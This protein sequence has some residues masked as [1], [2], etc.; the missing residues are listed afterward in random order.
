MELIVHDVVY[1]IWKKNVC[2]RLKLFL[3]LLKELFGI[4]TVLNHVLVLE[5]ALEPLFWCRLLADK[6]GVQGLSCSSISL[7]DWR[8]VSSL[9]LFWL[10]Q[11]SLLSAKC[12]FSNTAHAR[13]IA[14]SLP[15]PCSGHQFSKVIVVSPIQVLVKPFIAAF[16]GPK[17]PF[18]WGHQIEKDREV[19][20]TLAFHSC[21]I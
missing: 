3:G 18:H 9:Y 16:Q 6:R 21:H 8:I 13:L 11:F 12:P 7:I 20:L 10:F 15:L 5:V 17:W 14:S 1:L 19:E 2:F 4:I